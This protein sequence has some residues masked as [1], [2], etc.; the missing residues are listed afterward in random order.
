MSLVR[1]FEGFRPPQRFDSIPFISV[2]IQESATID[3][4]YT[5]IDTIAL[6]P[7][8]VDPSQPASRDITTPNAQLDPGWYKLFWV[9]ANSSFFP[10]EPISSSREDEPFVSVEELGEYLGQNL[11]DSAKA[12]IAV[13]SACDIVRS[14]T[15]Q[16]LNEI[17]SDSIKLDGTDTDAL[18]LPQQPVTS[19]IEVSDGA[20]VLVADDD[21]KLDDNGVLLKPWPGVW[22]KGRQNISVTYNHG[23]PQSVFPDDLRAVALDIAARIFQQAG[24]GGNI[25]TETIG[26]YSVR[27]DAAGGNNI[28]TLNHDRILAKYRVP[29]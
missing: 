5:S 1:T 17:L 9:D 11:T 20:T 10:S 4:V 27:Y 18:L 19:I 3:G 16:V 13:E 12:Q 25:L 26:L 15:E 6:I 7:A 22:T 21:Y 14:L 23:Y 8:D 2:E 28:V 24:S 29:K